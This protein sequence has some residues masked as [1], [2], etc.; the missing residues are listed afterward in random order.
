MPQ[1]PKVSMAALAAFQAAR[2]ARYLAMLGPSPRVS[3]SSKARAASSRIA[4]AARTSMYASAMGNCTPWFAP[5]GRPK[6]RRERA[7]SEARSTK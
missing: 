6:T 4:A 5:M 2:E 7:Y 3:A 1:P